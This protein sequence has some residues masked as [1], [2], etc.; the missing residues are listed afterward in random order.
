M[1]FNQDTQFNI[2]ENNLRIAMFKR[3]IAEWNNVK[4]MMVEQNWH[5]KVWNAKFG[6]I[7]AESM[8]D[9]CPYSCSGSSFHGSIFGFRCN[10]YH[11]FSDDY[12]F[13]E[14]CHSFASI[15]LFDRFGSSRLDV[16]STLV[17]IDKEIAHLES[18]IKKM[19][20]QNEHMDDILAKFNATVENIRAFR[21]NNPKDV[22]DEFFGAIKD[23]TY[24]L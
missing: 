7:Y 10:N 5:N 15:E 4:K 13:Y 21:D 8:S 16:D 23:V 6:N 20:Y 24:Y 17:Q 2:N 22:V 12:K 14:D 18:E 9:D 11:P 19:E 3:F 1:R